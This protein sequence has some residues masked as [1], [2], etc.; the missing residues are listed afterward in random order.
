MVSADRHPKKEVAEA[1]SRA[2]QAGLEVVEI[3]RGHRWG[4]VSCASCAASRAVYTTPR[5]PGNHAKQ[6]DRFTIRHTHDQPHP[7]VDSPPYA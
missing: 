2:H 6:L 4:E 5:D 3:H 1:L 7:A